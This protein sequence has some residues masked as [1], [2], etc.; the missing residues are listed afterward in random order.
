LAH[1]IVDLEKPVH[2]VFDV[3]F[4]WAMFRI[5]EVRL[6]LDTVI[7]QGSRAPQL[8]PNLVLGEGFVGE[9]YLATPAL[10]AAGDGNTLG[11]DVL[12]ITPQ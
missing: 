3:K 9:S 8:L 10:E 4:Y 1:R 11:R 12:G 7:D 6:Q 5:G 2:T